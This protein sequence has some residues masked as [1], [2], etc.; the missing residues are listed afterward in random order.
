[1]SFARVGETLI[2]Y[3]F[4]GPAVA[5]VIVFSNSLGTDFRIW[6]RLIE[7]LG[8]DFRTVR[9]DKR[10]HGLSD[11]QPAP[12]T[13]EDHAG[14]L[15]GLLDHLEITDAIVCGLS[16]GGMI[17]QKVARLRPD[18]ARALILCDTAHKIGPAKM[19]DERMAI[20]EKEGLGAIAEAVLGRWFSAAFRTSQPEDLAGWRNLLLSTPMQGYL[21]TCAA[22]RDADLTKDAEAIELPALCVCGSEDGSTPPDLVRSLSE[23]LPN[24]R[25]HL[26]EGPGHL[27]CIETPDEL[28]EAVTAFLWDIGFWDVDFAERGQRAPW[29]VG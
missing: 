3:E 25:F 16:V 7:I 19:W 28:A 17:A 4:E 21:G 9:Y 5:P 20:V 18:L 8:D 6:D 24:G 13:I 15:I 26:I 12:Y 22:I 27:P 29:Q 2:H 23:I 14:D 11:V 1:M 10:G